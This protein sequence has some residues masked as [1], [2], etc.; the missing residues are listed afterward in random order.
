LTAALDFL[1]ALSRRVGFVVGNA[2]IVERINLLNDHCR[3]GI[4]RPIQEACIAAQTGAAAAYDARVARA[5]ERP[6]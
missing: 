3:V 5:S 1:C 4:F 2:E 6:Q